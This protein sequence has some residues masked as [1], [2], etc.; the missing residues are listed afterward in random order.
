MKYSRQ[1]TES[2]IQQALGTLRRQGRL[3]RLPPGSQP[4]GRPQGG[5]AS[6]SN[7]DTT[8]RR[9]GLH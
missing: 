3:K 8:G 4:A 1:I 7:P 9:G 6:G 2:D 5:P